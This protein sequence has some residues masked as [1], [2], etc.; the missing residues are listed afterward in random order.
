M[1][2]NVRIL[3]LALKLFV[4]LSF[5]ENMDAGLKSLIIDLVSVLIVVIVIIFNVYI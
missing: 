4:K 2:I 5:K 3:S 1:L